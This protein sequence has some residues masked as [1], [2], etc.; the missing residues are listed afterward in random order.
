MAGLQNT[1]SL[2]SSVKAVKR[3]RREIRKILSSETA[4]YLTGK[5]EFPSAREISYGIVTMLYNVAFLLAESAFYH[6]SA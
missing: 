2:G 3:V 1:D 5:P 4:S 6:A